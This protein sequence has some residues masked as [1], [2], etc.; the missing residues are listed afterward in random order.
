MKR[1]TAVFGLRRAV[2]GTAA[3]LLLFGA[4]LPVQAA[5]P[6]VHGRVLALDEDG[7][8]TGIVAGATIEFKGE[9]GG[10]AAQVTSDQSGYFRADLPA[11][12]YFYK[13]QAEGFK[14]EDHGRGIAL[15]RSEGYA[16]YNLSLTRG[17]NDPG[18]EPPAGPSAEIGVLRGR[19]LEKT[20]DGSLV[21]IPGATITLRKKDGDR[22]LAR[23]VSG[24]ADQ[25]GDGAGRYQIVLE[26]ASWQASVAAEGF[27]GLVDPKPIVVEEG[28]EA[29]RDFVLTRA[30]PEE[31]EGQGIKGTISVY[32]P[33]GDAAAPSQAQVFIVPLSGPQKPDQALSTDARG[34]YSRD[35]SAGR[36]EVVASVEGFLTARSG[37]REVFPGKYTIVNLT[38]VPERTAEEP[39]PEQLVFTGIVYEQLPGDRG[40][41]PLPGASMLIRHEKQA[42]ADAPRGTTDKQGQVSLPLA[43]EGEYV[44]L[45][46]MPGYAPG[47]AR[48]TISAGGENSAVITLQ[49]ESPETEPTPTPQPTPDEALVAVSGYVVYRSSESATGF[50]G[51]PESE[52]TWRRA[53]GG[54]P[55]ERRAAAGR[56]GR[57]D[58]ELPEGRYL[59]EVRPP[60]GFRG[61]T[62]EVVVQR[63]MKPKYFILA[64][65]PD[66]TPQPPPSRLV[67]VRGYVVTQS[68]KNITG[69]AGVPNVPVLWSD[70]RS[71]AQQTTMSG[72]GGQFAIL[73]PQGV[74]DV[75]ARAPR[76][77]RDAAE[78]V[79]VRRGMPAVSLVLTR[80]AGPGDRDIPPGQRPGALSL[81]VRVLTR[82]AAP[83]ISRLPGGA[84]LRPVAG[85]EVVVRRGGRSVASNPSDSNGIASFR[86]PPG[87]YE[88]LVRYEG[89]QPGHETVQLTTRNVDRNVYLRT[90]RRELP[91]TPATLQLRVVARAPG[92]RLQ[93]TVPRT[94]PVPGARIVISRQGKPVDSGQSDKGG[95]YSARLRPGT[96]LV[97][98]AHKGFQPA[99][100]SVTLKGGIVRREITLS[101]FAVLNPRLQ[102]PELKPR[103]QIQGKP[104]KTAPQ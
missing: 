88:I 80:I 29:T 97:A 66:R 26:A 7:K 90:G 101:K 52:L 38:L 98:V 20:R 69:L 3:L 75:R 18:H 6:G 61:A 34:R 76:G 17:E 93:M 99:Q 67:T 39:E 79:E 11:G 94:V 5:G 2:F 91:Q 92:G 70:P 8:V 45:A 23:V 41:R 12:R 42:L 37:P 10:V 103:L 35:L 65:V 81:N 74:Y 58:L 22:G 40:R 13:V 48:V 33:G 84:G 96:Y 72:G 56:I 82:F 32:R 51:I 21:G 14:D 87:N 30:A 83:T 4:A 54:G 36:Y 63:G 73:L 47:G 68:F 19:V 53:D 102:V 46:Q 31:P 9:G 49:R 71:G 95:L 27:D 25:T 104:Q 86:L 62:E 64:R 77:F 89:Y 15:T 43:E 55:L 59:V 57:Y 16:V 78:R 1:P 44:A 28:K 85:A 100:V 50:F 60:S 24:G